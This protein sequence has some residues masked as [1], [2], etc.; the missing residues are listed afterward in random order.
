MNCDKPW[1]PRRDLVRCGIWSTFSTCW[2]QKNTTK[3]GGL[4]GCKQGKGKRGF[5]IHQC[6][7]VLFSPKNVS[8]NKL[9]SCNVVQMLCR[10]AFGIS[11]IYNSN[12]GRIRTVMAVGGIDSIPSQ[13]GIPCG[14]L[15][16]F[17]Q[18]NGLLIANLCRSLFAKIYKP[19]C[20]I[21]GM[22]SCMYHKYYIT[23]CR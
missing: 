17:P 19:I 14:A 6:S 10:S 20:S 13:R 21:Y 11:I 18:M 1:L 22:F 7:R 15:K 9:D 2:Y 12:K 5:K 16:C 8:F 4:I 23:K 3:T